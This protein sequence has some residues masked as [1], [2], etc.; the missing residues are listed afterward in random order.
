MLAG[1][2]VLLLRYAL[3]QRAT[4]S[5]VPA[6]FS[7]A[8]HDAAMPSLGERPDLDSNQGPTP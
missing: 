2:S 4:G 1:T 7:R 8:D 3:Y 6:A 5:A